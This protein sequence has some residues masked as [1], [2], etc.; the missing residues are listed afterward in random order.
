MTFMRVL[1]T[2]VIVQLG[3]A[4]SNTGTL[5]AQ[6]P[7]G[8]PPPCVRA[9]VRAALPSNS[10]AVLYFDN[11][12]R[13]TSD[14][15]LADGLTDELTARLGRI[16]GLFVLGRSV[17]RR[18]RNASGQSLGVAYLVTGSVR[19]SGTRLRVTVELV[20]TTSGV[21][22]WGEIY[23]RRSNDLL[24][25]EEDIAHQVVL[26]VTGQVLPRERTGLTKSRE[27]YDHYLRGLVHL[28]RRLDDASSRARAVHEFETAVTIDPMFVS[29]Y[30]QIGK[31]YAGMLERSGAL[32]GVAADTALARGLAAASRALQLDS[33]SAEG[34][35][36]LGALH[37][38]KAK[39][40]EDSLGPARALAAYRRGLALDP[41]NADSHNAYGVLLLY[42]F[43]DADTSR[44]A[45]ERALQLD[46]VHP[47]YL[48]NM[49]LV[50]F[51]ARRFAESERWCDSA[52]AV[53]PRAAIVYED[54]AMVRL[55][56]G[57]TAGARG[58]AQTAARLQPDWPWP[59]AI[60]ALVDLGHGD[61]AGARSTAERLSAEVPVPEALRGLSVAALLV[62]LGQQE[63]AMDYLERVRPRVGYTLPLVLRYVYLDPLHS[64][65]RFQRLV[66]EA[67]PPGWPL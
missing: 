53:A 7:D 59:Q 30:A 57:D 56:L 62:A 39:L 27:A 2:C 28:S 45:I 50:T 8:S 14:A 40:D 42:S 67:Q 20:R 61:T 36:A 47:T 63:P 17:V 13:D 48:Q 12:S 33:N 18:H 6:C 35:M 11:L 64:S 55:V 54:R 16:E 66:Q 43:G 21:R 46:P 37:N 58:D 38:R 32:T 31:C 26:A 34:W 5:S 52:A 24:D 29:A 19:R 4:L 60:M 1:I 41:R 10:I 23:D 9:K 65:P 3:S 44:A 15:Y 25:V 49:A 22:V 51:L